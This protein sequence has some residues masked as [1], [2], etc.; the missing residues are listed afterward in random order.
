MFTKESG[1][2]LIARGPG[3][4]KSEGNLKF[5][6]QT[7]T[8]FLRKNSFVIFFFTITEREA[9]VGITIHDVLGDIFST[10]RFLK[11]FDFF[12]VWLQS[13]K[14]KFKQVAL[15]P[16]KLYQNPRINPKGLLFHCESKDMLEYFSTS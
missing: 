7:P 1:T 3:D 12:Y 5:E 4:N 16:L 8:L 13:P 11:Y 9:V 15:K 2:V 10:S 14:E 6:G